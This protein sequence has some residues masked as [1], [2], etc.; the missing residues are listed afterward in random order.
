MQRLARYC[1]YAGDIVTLRSLWKVSAANGTVGANNDCLR[2]E[3][4]RTKS[5]TAYWW[6]SKR[7]GLRPV[8]M[9][10]GSVRAT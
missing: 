9:E 7:Y 4:N 2:S 1:D 6:V 3:T 10:L 5:L 8:K